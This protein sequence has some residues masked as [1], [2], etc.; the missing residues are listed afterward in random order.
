M[1]PSPPPPPPPPPLGTRLLKSGPRMSS[2]H[3]AM[4]IIRMES[5]FHR[6]H[7]FRIAHQGDVTFATTI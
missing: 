3:K 6:V 4:N 7:P 5:A 2:T 1:S